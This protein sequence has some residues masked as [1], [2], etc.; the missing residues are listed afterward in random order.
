MGVGTHTVTYSYTDGNGCEQ[1]IQDDVIVH[2]LPNVNLALPITEDC[3]SNSTLLLSGATPGGGTF[4]GNGVTGNNFD[5]S[6]AGQGNHLITYT[7][8]DAN[9]CE[10]EATDVITVFPIPEVELKLS[11]DNALSL[12]H[13]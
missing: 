1:S 13:I 2:D 7:F 3:E 5:A 12:I 11:I 8:V 9:G 6:A 4:S 10:S